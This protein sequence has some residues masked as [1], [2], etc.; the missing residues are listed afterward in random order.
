MFTSRDIAARIKRQPFRPIRIVT[1]SG[2]RVEVRHPDLTMIGQRDVT[3]G[4]ASKDDPEFYDRQTYVSILHITAI[5]DLTAE[6]S[7]RPR[8]GDGDR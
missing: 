4:I 3:V 5:E 7:P 8:N 6:I 2:E 1:S